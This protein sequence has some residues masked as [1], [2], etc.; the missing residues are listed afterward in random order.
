MA[1]VPHVTRDTDNLVEGA[2]AGAA[3]GGRAR[4][5]ERLG[6]GYRRVQ[7]LLAQERCVMLDGGI[8]TE[9]GRVLP[10]EKPS[11][12]EALWDTWALVHEP[13]AV[14]DVHRSYLDAGCDVISTNTW[15][16]T[17]EL[18]RHAPGGF[19]TPVH[20]M[21]IARRGLRVGREAIEQAGR[22]DEVALAF[23]INGDVD[24]D[25]R[26][27]ML[28]LLPRVFEEAPP[29]LVLLETMTLV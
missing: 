1:L 29:D 15:G 28:E 26:R 2:P 20:W 14:R 6:S 21:D 25:A 13:G 22:R 3:N 16:L 17:G 4:R 10:D 27:E 9:L 5:F 8:A 23:S 18:D 19:S 11:H 12:E 7:E 24:G